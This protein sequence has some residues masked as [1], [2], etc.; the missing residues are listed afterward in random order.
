[1]KED[2]I[3]IFTPPF[4]RESTKRVP[5]VPEVFL[6]CGHYKDL[7]E[8]GNRARKV[9]GTQGTNRATKHIK[10][11]ISYIPWCFT[12]NFCLLFVVE[13]AFEGFEGDYLI[14]NVKCFQSHFTHYCSRLR[15]C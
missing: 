1:M 14:D 10:G 5:W 13:R 7:T 9:S 12:V 2:S 15:P 4:I 6:T 11:G 8:I 3:D